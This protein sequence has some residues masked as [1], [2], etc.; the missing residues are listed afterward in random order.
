MS[1]L[2]E[3]NLTACPGDN[4]SHPHTKDVTKPSQQ[5]HRSPLKTNLKKS[6][7]S[8]IIKKDFWVYI[9]CNGIKISSIAVRVQTGDIH[10]LFLPWHYCHSGAKSKN[11]K[12]VS[13][14]G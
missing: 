10:P 14:T 7:P 11:V 9:K 2:E 5:G 3:Y 1:R 12:A 6:K 13:G 4:L 8:H